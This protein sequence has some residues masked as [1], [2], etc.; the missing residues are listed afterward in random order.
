MATS[1]IMQ[2][3]PIYPIS[4]FI[5]SPRSANAR[6]ASGKIYLC[7]TT[8]GPSVDSNYF[9]PAAPALSFPPSLVLDIEI[10]GKSTSLTSINNLTISFKLNDLLYFEKQTARWSRRLPCAPAPPAS[11][12]KVTHEINNSKQLAK[13]ARPKQRQKR[14]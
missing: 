3:T 8:C 11:K 7:S 6:S 2:I 4:S 1:R 5:W 12:P 9:F 10:G 13:W 14:E